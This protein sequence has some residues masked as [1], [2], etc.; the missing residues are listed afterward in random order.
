MV[1]FSL[2]V[3]L[4]AYVALYRLASLCIYMTFGLSFSRS[5]RPVEKSVSPQSGLRRGETATARE[6]K[7]VDRDRLQTNVFLPPIAPSVV[8]LSYFQTLPPLCHVSVRRRTFPLSA[9]LTRKRVETLRTSFPH[10]S[11]VPS[12]TRPACLLVLLQSAR[13]NWNFL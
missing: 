1:C 3:G 13:Q 5:P 10:L 4:S 11:P 12:L 6:E 2:P 8:W 7:R 9:L